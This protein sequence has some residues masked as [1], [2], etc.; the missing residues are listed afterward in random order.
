MEVGGGGRGCDTYPSV[1]RTEVCK[2]GAKRAGR[3][4]SHVATAY[5]HGDAVIELHKA[6]SHCVI[7]AIIIPHAVIPKVNYCR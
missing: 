2:T 5:I 3:V 4:G 7:P 1:S 6:S